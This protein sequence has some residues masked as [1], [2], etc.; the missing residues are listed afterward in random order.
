[1]PTGAA[2][3][4][5]SDTWHSPPADSRELNRCTAS[6]PTLYMSLL[7]LYVYLMKL[8]KSLCHALGRRLLDWA[9]TVPAVQSK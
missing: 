3:S 6:C 7:M 2:A 1:M 5:L 9:D 4:L 8:A